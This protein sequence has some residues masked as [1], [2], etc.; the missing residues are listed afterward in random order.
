MNMY[1][2]SVI[3]NEEIGIKIS[4]KNQ[5]NKYDDIQYYIEK[6]LLKS[7][8][9]K[10]EKPQVQEEDISEKIDASTGLCILCLKEIKF[11]KFKSLCYDCFMKNKEFNPIHGKYCHNCG[12][13][14]Y[15]IDNHYPLCYICY[16]KFIKSN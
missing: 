6:L 16:R 13:K 3:N 12:K 2:H 5:P 10:V 1:L 15:N 14:D 11:D 7:A 9:F 4:K 8:E